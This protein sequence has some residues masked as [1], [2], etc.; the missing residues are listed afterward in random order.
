MNLTKAF[1]KSKDE[2][3]PRFPKMEIDKPFSCVLITRGFLWGGYYWWFDFTHNLCHNYEHLYGPRKG[4]GQYVH[5]GDSAGVVMDTTNGD[6]SFA[7]D[8]VDLGVA[9]EGIPLDKPLVLC[10]I[11]R[12]K[13]DSIELLNLIP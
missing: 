5:R 11:L 4:D 3:E 6:L 8:G 12:Y 1:N 10:V 13:D 9:Y 7:L 2:K